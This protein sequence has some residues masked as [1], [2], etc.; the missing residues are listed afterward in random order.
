[1]TEDIDKFKQEYYTCE[2]GKYNLAIQVPHLAKLAEDYT[3]RYLKRGQWPD[4]LKVI[5]NIKCKE[6]FCINQAEALHDS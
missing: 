5:L 3:Q 4:C 2:N 1:M 6:L